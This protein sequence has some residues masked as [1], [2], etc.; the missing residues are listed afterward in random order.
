MQTSESKS[1]TEEDSNSHPVKSCETKTSTEDGNGES[2]AVYDDRIS[3]ENVALKKQR[4]ICSVAPVKRSAVYDDDD[5]DKTS[6]ESTGVKKQ[7]TTCSTV[8]VKKLNKKSTYTNDKIGVGLA[9]TQKTNKKLQQAVRHR[10][11]I[12]RDVTLRTMEN[13]EV[14]LTITKYCSQGGQCKI[15]NTLVECVDFIK[16][17]AQAIQSIHNYISKCGCANCLEYLNRVISINPIDSM[18]CEC[19]DC[20]VFYLYHNL[21]DFEYMFQKI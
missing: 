13:D 5:D 21:S 14:K 17:P 1:S 3:T 6:T 10:P 8:P 11:E 7:R 16:K 15:P 19:E 2:S 20:S 9:L 4:T 18:L 12:G